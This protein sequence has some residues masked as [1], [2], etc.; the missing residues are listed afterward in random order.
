MIWNFNVIFLISRPLVCANTDDYSKFSSW[1]LCYSWMVPRNQW[2]NTCWVH[3]TLKNPNKFFDWEQHKNC[4]W[5]IKLIKSSGTECEAS[6][7]WWNQ[8]ALN[9]WEKRLSIN[10]LCYFINLIVVK[11]YYIREKPLMSIKSEYARY[12]VNIYKYLANFNIFEW[13]NETH[14]PSVP[15]C[16]SQQIIDHLILKYCNMLLCVI[17]CCN[18]L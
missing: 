17:I 13:W 1:G 15:E 11:I 16:H 10:K 3:E 2:K 14:S 18:M 8:L 12:L 7:T 4:V 9:S 5:D 6:W